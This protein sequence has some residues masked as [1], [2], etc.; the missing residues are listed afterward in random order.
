MNWLTSE[1]IINNSGSLMTIQEGKPLGL[2]YGLKK[3]GLGQISP[4]TVS[5]EKY[6]ND[7]QQTPSPENPTKWIIEKLTKESLILKTAS[8]TL[9]FSHRE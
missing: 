2:I 6:I 5:I 8:D 9:F 7:K 1:A 4:D 3:E